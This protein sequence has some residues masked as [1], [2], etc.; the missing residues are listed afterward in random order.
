M[1]GF[2][3]VLFQVLPLEDMLRIGGNY[4]TSRL[5]DIKPLMLE[6]KLAALDNTKPIINQAKNMLAKTVIVLAFL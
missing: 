2:L 3:I 4:S 1:T 5:E 6:E